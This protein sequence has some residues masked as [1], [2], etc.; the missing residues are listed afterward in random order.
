MPG[1]CLQP[2]EGDSKVG[3]LGFQPG[4]PPTVIRSAPDRLIGPGHEILEVHRM[5]VTDS[6]LLAT[7]REL[8]P[9]I[10]AHGLQH[11]EPGP[12][13]H[14]HFLPD[15]VFGYQR[16]LDVQRIV[17][18]AVFRGGD[19]FGGLERAAAGEHRQPP[20]DVLLF[21]GQEVVALGNRASQRPL[22]FGEIPGPAGEEREAM[23]EPLEQGCWRQVSK[24]G[25]GQLDCQR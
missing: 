5:P 20:E 7:H 24:P 9:P 16:G 10:L 22:A 1:G 17:T 14:I 18:C 8:L 4:Q 2:G 11:R 25:R 21:R 6:M 3:K 19:S 13:V 12:A 23:V 15:E